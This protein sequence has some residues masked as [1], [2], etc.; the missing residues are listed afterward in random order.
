LTAAGLRDALDARVEA[1]VRPLRAWRPQISPEVARLGLITIPR[2]AALRH[3]A[4]NALFKVVKRLAFGTIDAGLYSTAR[5]ALIVTQASGLA[6][7]SFLLRTAL[8][9]TPGRRARLAFGERT[10]KSTP[11][12]R[13][14]DAEDHH[15]EN[16]Y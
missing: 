5:G 8:D 15:E 16:R 6:I 12:L 2:R 7:G 13:A 10:D 3:R 1:G 9:V 14:G 11:V 4:S